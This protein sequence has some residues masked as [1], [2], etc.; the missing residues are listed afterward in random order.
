MACRNTRPC[1]RTPEGRQPTPSQP[2][3]S[4]GRCRSS[5]RRHLAY[6]SPERHHPAPRVE[7]NLPLEG[8]GLGGGVVWP[9]C[10]DPPPN[11]ATHLPISLPSTGVPSGSTRGPLSTRHNRRMALNAAPAAPPPPNLPHQ[12]GGADPACGI[13]SPNKCRARHPAPNAERNLP[14]EGGGLGGGGAPRTS[15]RGSQIDGPPPQ[16]LI[17]TPRPA[18]ILPP[19]L[20][21][22]GGAAATGVRS[23]SREG[24]GRAQPWDERTRHSGGGATAIRWGRRSVFR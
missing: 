6:E 1:P 14:L 12:G 13:I 8:G 19:S 7:R 2:P 24:W 20:R 11:A 17:P 16:Y 4:W 10:R 15:A 18:P 9:R 5:M 21:D 22:A 23:A 3:P